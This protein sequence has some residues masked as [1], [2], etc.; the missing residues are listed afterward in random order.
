MLSRQNTSL[1]LLQ[2]PLASRDHP[3]MHAHKA[4]TLWLADDQLITPTVLPR[5]AQ[6]IEIAANPHRGAGGRSIRKAGLWK[7]TS[8]LAC[9]PFAQ[10]STQ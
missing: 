8:D 9:S 10:R 2:N 1:V 4:I 6:R 3:V 7:R 5:Y